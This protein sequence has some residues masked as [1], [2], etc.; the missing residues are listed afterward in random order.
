MAYGDFLDLLRELP[1]VLV[2]FGLHLP[3]TRLLFNLLIVAP[4]RVRLDGRATERRNT[5]IVNTQKKKKKK[6]K[7]KQNPK[8][9][10][11]KTQIN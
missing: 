3:L 1:E 5:T 11:T 9:K 4:L 7:N 2:E 6:Q 8:K 10:K